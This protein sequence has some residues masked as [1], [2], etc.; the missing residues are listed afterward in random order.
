MNDNK[1]FTLV[2]ALVGMAIMMFVII[3]ILSTFLHQQMVTR[4]T[5][6]KNTAVILAEM[7]IE[8]LL[9]FSSTQLQGEPGEAID[10]IFIK[11]GRFEF[12]DYDPMDERHEQF[13]RTT[14]ISNDLLG[15]MV[16]IIVLV[17]YGRVENTYPF[18]ITLNT[19]RGL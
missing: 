17:E 1:G 10:Y 8:E 19:R 9:K 16:T 7:K 12:Y 13:K 15:Q 2:E 18:H 3:S 14:T 4:K 5:S 6:E 11:D